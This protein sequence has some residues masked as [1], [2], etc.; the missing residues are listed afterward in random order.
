MKQNFKRNCL[1][2]LTQ[3]NADPLFYGRLSHSLAPF[4][5]KTV[6]LQTKSFRMKHL[7]DTKFLSAFA[8]LNQV[9]HRRQMGG[10]AI[11]FTTLGLAKISSKD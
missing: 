5:Q 2:H 11:C 4:H 10:L 7:V 8:A 3:H 6:L 1:L 9:D